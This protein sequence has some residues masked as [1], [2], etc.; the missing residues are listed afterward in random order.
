MKELLRLFKQKRNNI[1]FPE[2]PVDPV[3]SDKTRG[4][5]ALNIVKCNA[6]RKCESACPSGAI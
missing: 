2:L 4:I 5:L 6:C 1:K 3:L